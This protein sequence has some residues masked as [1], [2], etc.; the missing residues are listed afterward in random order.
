MYH[1]PSGALAM[2][3]LVMMVAGG[4]EVEGVEWWGVLECM[5]GVLAVLKLE[6]RMKSEVTVLALYFQ[7]LIG[8][9]GRSESHVDGRMKLGRAA[10]RFCML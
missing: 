3:V 6:L 9:R 5:L 10:R 7:L 1:L 2:L 4:V 8:G